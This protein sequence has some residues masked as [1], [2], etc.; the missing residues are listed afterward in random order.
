MMVPV[1]VPVAAQTAAAT[2]GLGGIFG[3]FN[4]PSASAPTSPALLMDADVNNDNEEMP[5]LLLELGNGSNDG[6]ELPPLLPM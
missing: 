6:G 1:A 5:P 2:V 3:A 4:P